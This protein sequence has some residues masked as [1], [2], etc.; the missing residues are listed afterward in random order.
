MLSMINSRLPG[1]LSGLRT[2]FA[3]EIQFARPKC[4]YITAPF[5]S[6]AHDDTPERMAKS[7]SQ[8]QPKQSDS[9]S[10]VST[11]PKPGTRRRT[12]RR[13][14]QSLDGGGG[15]GGDDAIPSLA[16]FMHRTK[17]LKQY[18][19]FVRLARF[20][21]G[22]DAANGSSGADPGKLRAALE[23]V[24]LSYKLGMKKDVDV[25]SKSMSY[26][27]GERRLRE[28]EAMVG[29]SANTRSKESNEISPESYDSDS[30]INIQDEE[31]PRGRVGL[32]WPWEQD[33]GTSK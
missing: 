6:A 31:D 27:E 4:L 25:L 29:Y 10:R 18:R 14:I 2:R 9:V 22:K 5:S 3:S 8:S 15:G 7:Q 11:P 28:L 30:W 17:V 33:E 23:E 13:T 21:D 1:S 20:V 32:Q 16:D 12:R 19:N 26:S 24:R